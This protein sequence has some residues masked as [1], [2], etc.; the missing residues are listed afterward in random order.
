MTNLDLDFHD[1]DTGHSGA[2]ASTWG[3]GNCFGARWNAIAAHK[4]LSAGDTFSQTTSWSSNSAAITSGN[5][6]L[7]AQPIVV[8]SIPYKLMIFDTF[9]QLVVLPQ[10]VQSFSFEDVVNG[11]SGQGTF[12]CKRAF[13]DQGWLDYDYRVQLYIAE[14]IY[15]WYD[16]RIVEFDPQQ[17]ASNDEEGITVQCEGWH[18][19]LANSIVSEVLTPS[20]V[21][22]PSS[23]A[24]YQNATIVYGGELSADQYLIHLLSTY[25]DDTSFSYAPIPAITQYLDGFTFDGQ[26]LD[27]C[28]DDIVKQVLDQ[29]GQIYEWWVRGPAIN[30]STAGIIGPGLPELVIQPQQLPPTGTITPASTP[31]GAPTTLNALTLPLQKTQFAGGSTNLNGVAP[32]P[33]YVNNTAGINDGQ[34]DM[35]F[36]YEF[37]DS[38]IYEYQIQNNSRGLFN[39]IALY[40][41]LLNNVQTYGAFYLANSVS[42]YGVRQEKV[43]NT[44]LLSATTLADYATAYLALHGYPQ[45]QGSFKKYALDD[46]ARA[47]QWFS[48]FLPGVQKAEIPENGNSNDGTMYVSAPQG[49]V[50]DVPVGQ[51][52]GSTASVVVQTTVPPITKITPTTPTELFKGVLPLNFTCRAVRVLVS[53][54]EGTNRIEQQVFLTAPRPFLDHAFYGA[55]NF[56]LTQAAGAAGKQNPAQLSYYYI[57]GGGEILGP[58]ASANLIPDPDFLIGTKYSNGRA[59]APYSSTWSFAQ[60]DNQAFWLQMNGAVGEL[61]ININPATPKNCMALSSRF[62]LLPGTYTL[63]FDIDDDTTVEGGT[64]IL[65]VIQDKGLGTVATDYSMQPSTGNLYYLA[66]TVHQTTTQ[67]MTGTFTNSATN[68]P[69]ARVLFESKSDFGANPTVLAMSVRNM[70]LEFTP[71]G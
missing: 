2:V 53:M 12:F 6:I 4:F 39:M 13:V 69:Y 5:V 14:S 9:G 8:P 42:Y 23:P 65:S 57:D 22:T 51:I 38:T 45:P 24:T 20:A 68:I 71:L 50:Y 17:F 3:F 30:V 32:V 31:T 19:K 16:G 60:I 55:I 44:N 28:I 34:K 27:T 29:T 1:D 7:A 46:H 64:P 26:D 66:A 35:D 61:A 47:G 11:G 48:I 10:D 41:G 56:S 49:A 62:P 25:V 58:G 59:I 52:A 15:P 33:P 18:T 43:T 67:S 36:I 63:S 21:G 54:Q 40:G 70:K 37:K